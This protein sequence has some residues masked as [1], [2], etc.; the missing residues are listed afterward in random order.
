[1]LKTYTRLR[2]VNFVESGNYALM[3]KVSTRRS[4]REGVTTV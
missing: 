4:R 2:R 1:M 3:L